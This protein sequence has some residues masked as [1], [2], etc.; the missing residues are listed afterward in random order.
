[1]ASHNH[2]VRRI[3]DRVYSSAAFRH[4]FHGPL[5]DASRIGLA[6]SNVCLT[7]ICSAVNMV[8][9]RHRKAIPEN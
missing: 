9:R 2:L 4:N 7:L 1:M 6:Y 8:S 5:T 3:D